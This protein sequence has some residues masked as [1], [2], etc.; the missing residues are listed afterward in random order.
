MKIKK[1]VVKSEEKKLIYVEVYNPLVVDTDGEAMTADEIEQAAHNFALYSSACKVDVAHNGI[2]TGNVIVESFIVRHP[3]DPDGF[4]KGAWVVGIKFFNE[5][6]WEQAKR[7]DINSVSLS[8][9]ADKKKALVKASF[10]KHIVLDTENS[11]D[12][13]LPAHVHK[14]DIVFDIKDHISSG[15]TTEVF[16]HTHSILKTCSTVKTLEHSHRIIIEPGDNLG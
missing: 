13:L 14:A 3:D 16:G 12:G 6:H 1:S 15:R 2:E 11:F 10:I 4:N 5:D 7:G 9:M 8:G